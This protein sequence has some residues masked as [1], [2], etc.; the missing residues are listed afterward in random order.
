MKKLFDIKIVLLALSLP[1][2]FSTHSIA[3][4]KKVMKQSSITEL[5]PVYF[6]AGRD[7][8]KDSQIIIDNA[9]WLKKNTDK[10]VVIEGHCDER[11]D[12]DYNMR[13]GDR[14]ARSVMKALLDEGVSENQLILMSYGKSKP[15]VTKNNS[16][17]WAENRRVSLVVR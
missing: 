12:S 1:L 7:Q 15:V 3:R 13:L 9:S 5:S 6:D 11:G 16:N 14:R 4:E 17:G 10:V 8:V 2:L